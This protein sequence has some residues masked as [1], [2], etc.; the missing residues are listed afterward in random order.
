MISVYKIPVRES[1]LIS[2][3]KIVSIQV[4]ELLVI[5][6]G[7]L[8]NQMAQNNVKTSFRQIQLLRYCYLHLASL[9]C[10]HPINNNFYFPALTFQ[11]FR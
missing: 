3:V 7:L 10:S 5:V 11:V 4:A 1:A 6:V 2:V 9:Y 8:T